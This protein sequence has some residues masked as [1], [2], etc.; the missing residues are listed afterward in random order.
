MCALVFVDGVYKAGFA[1]TQTAYQNAVVGIFESLDK[2]EKL[3]TGKNYF[4]GNQLTEADIRL[5]VTIVRQSW[6]FFFIPLM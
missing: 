2:L 6:L 1:S 4:F 3:L 5:W